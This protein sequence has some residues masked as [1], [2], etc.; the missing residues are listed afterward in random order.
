LQQDLL[1]A[2]EFP[3]RRKHSAHF[4]E[5]VARRRGD[6]ATVGLAAQAILNHDQFADLRLAFFAVGVRPVLAGAAQMLVN[7]P[8]TPALLSRVSGTLVEELD[9]PEDQQASPAMRRHLAKV[10]LARCVSALLSRQ[11]L[12]AGGGK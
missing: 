1:V 8:V 12:G 10:L 5:E 11:D 6:Y 4:F 3:A 9:P 2:I 7:A